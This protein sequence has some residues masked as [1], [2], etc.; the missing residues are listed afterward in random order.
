M[1]VCGREL[2]EDFYEIIP[3]AVRDLEKSLD[4]SH[5]PDRNFS[6]ENGGS[7]SAGPQGNTG[8]C[9]ESTPAQVSHTI[10]IHPTESQQ[11]QLQGTVVRRR[12]KGLEGLI[13]SDE[14]GKW[15]LPVFQEKRYGAKAVHLPVKH[16]NSDETLFIAMKKHYFASTTRLHRWFSMRDVK[17]I[18]H[19]KVRSARV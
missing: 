15:I 12:R 19:V 10:S 18:H 2:Y 16:I 14:A 17:K 3:G 9:Q 13:A 6:P 7:T 8:T 1:K 5:N 11:H 4:F